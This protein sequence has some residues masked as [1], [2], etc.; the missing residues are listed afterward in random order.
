MFFAFAAHSLPAGY[1]AVLNATVPLFTV[2]IGWAGGTRPS[3]SKLAGVVVGVILALTLN[4]LVERWA[5]GSSRD[6]LTLIA[7]LALL[8]FISFVAC[9]IP[10]RHATS[11]SPMSALRFD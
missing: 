5:G 1:S 6:P 10:A 4:G 2:L 9:A 3:G 7:V 11:I 8:C